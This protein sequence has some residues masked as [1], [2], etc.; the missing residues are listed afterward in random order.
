MRAGMLLLRIGMILAILGSG[1]A[2]TD[3]ST[4]HVPQT[5]VTT[6]SPSPASTAPSHPHCGQIDPGGKRYRAVFHPNHGPPGTL[7]T[8][9][10][11]TLRGEEGRYSPENAVEL[12]WNESFP[13]FRV[14]RRFEGHTFI[15][16]SN[17]NVLGRCRFRM[18][19]RVPRVKSGLYP[20]DKRDYWW[21]GYGIFVYPFRV[22]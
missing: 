17:A 14:H 1:F 16:A 12:R 10:G 22:T 21:G 20:I 9:A 8:V 15:V 13:G 19:F 4:T 5:R 7:V 11:P 2:L 18:E 3:R 6:S